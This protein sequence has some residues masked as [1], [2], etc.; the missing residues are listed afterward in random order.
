MAGLYDAARAANTKVAKALDMIHRNA[1]KRAIV[2]TL[3]GALTEINEELFAGDE[4]YPETL[5]ESCKETSIN[6]KAA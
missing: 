1:D 4:I 5:A 3:Y 6:D 2:S